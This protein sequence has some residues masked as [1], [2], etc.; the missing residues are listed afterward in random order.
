MKSQGR[1]LLVVTDASCEEVVGSLKGSPD[2]DQAKAFEEKA[3]EAT[4]K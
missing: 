3:A 1:P 2:R 4:G